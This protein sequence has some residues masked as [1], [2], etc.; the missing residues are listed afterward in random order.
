MGWV[1]C[2]IRTIA[3]IECNQ[4]NFHYLARHLNSDGNQRK[5]SIAMENL[6]TRFAI[7]ARKSS[8]SKAKPN[9]THDAANNG[10]S[11]F[12][13]LID[14]VHISMGWNHSIFVSPSI[15]SMLQ[16][17][18]IFAIKYKEKPFRI[19]N[20]FFFFL[21]PIAFKVAANRVWR[22]WKWDGIAKKKP[23]S[24]LMLSCYQIMNDIAINSICEWDD[25]QIWHK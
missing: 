2:R 14:E 24:E 25:S 4:R 23:I 19:I 12:Y 3:I 20:N 22:W 5:I 9:W 13:L 7:Y 15:L 11:L 8:I 6:S 16:L 17:N 18:T 10:T 21:L 1:G